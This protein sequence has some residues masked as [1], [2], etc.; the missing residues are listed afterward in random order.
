MTKTRLT[1]PSARSNSLDNIDGG[2]ERGV[3]T[4]MRG[5]EQAAGGPHFRRSDHKEL[6]VGAGRDDGA[7]IAAVEHGA[8]RPHREFALVVD[9]GLANLRDR[10]HH[11]GGFGDR[12]QFQRIFLIFFWIEPDRD[13]GG[14]LGVVRRIAG[15]EHG[16][17]DGAVEKTGV[18]MMQAIDRRDLPRDR[19][20]AGRGWTIDRNDHRRLPFAAAFIMSRRPIPMTIPSLFTTNRRPGDSS[21]RRSPESSWR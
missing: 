15:I 1:A 16:L 21:I 11:R 18:E 4:Q 3:Y 2:P 14:L 10:S 20:F 6:Y 13:L 7:D 5:V 17:G 12:L 19:A 8:G 9:Q